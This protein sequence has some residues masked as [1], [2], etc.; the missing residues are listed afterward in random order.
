MEVEVA[1]SYKIT[2]HSIHMQR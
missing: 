1:L 2:C